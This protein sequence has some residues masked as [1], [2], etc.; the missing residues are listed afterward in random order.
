[1]CSTSNIIK[2]CSWNIQGLQK[3][4]KRQAVLPFLEREKV[5]V[6]FL[7]ETHLEVK[8]NVKLKRE[9]VVQMFATFYSSFSMGVAILINR[10]IGFCCLNSIRDDHGQYIIVKGILFGKEVTFMNLYCPPGYLSF[11]PRLL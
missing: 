10:K 9:L 5:S 6:A 8:D 2:L 7:Q 1:M 11:S 3:S 4:T